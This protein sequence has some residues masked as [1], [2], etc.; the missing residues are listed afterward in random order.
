M[1]QHAFFI[2]LITAAGIFGSSPQS[3]AADDF[4][5]I[6][7]EI[8]K[9]HDE[10][11][12][13]LQE[14]IKQV[15]I[16]AEN[17]GYPEGPDFMMKLLREAGFDHIIQVPTGGKAGVFGTLNAGAKKTVGVYFMYDVKQYDPAEWSSPPL[18]AALIDK[19]GV[20]KVMM[21]RGT[22]NQKGPQL[23]FLY[24]LHAIRAAG[25]KLPVNLVLV[26]E[27]RWGSSS[28]RCP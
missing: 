20:G 26:A 14:W 16:A 27:G 13:R 18:D 15:S 7:T 2:G 28:R 3:S 19:P 4:T 25:K 10:S 12:K 5:A 11:V 24:A 23:A 9:Q 21:G 17:R 8:A 6:K 22:V 1:K